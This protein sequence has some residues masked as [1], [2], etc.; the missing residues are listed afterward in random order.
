MKDVHY[1]VKIFYNYGFYYRLQMCVEF[2]I[3][4]NLHSKLFRKKW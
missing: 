4:V 1:Y 3:K 2:L